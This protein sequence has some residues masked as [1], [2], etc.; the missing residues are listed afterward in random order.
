MVFRSRA[1]RD[2]CADSEAM[3]TAW[4][5]AGARVVRRTLQQLAATS[6]LGDLA[7]LPCANN[8]Q[9]D[10]RV[11]IKL[12]EGISMVVSG[13]KESVEIRE[14]IHDEMIVIEQIRAPRFK[15]R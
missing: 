9:S 4:G 5:F 15:Q 14:A 11:E 2:R 8:V 10:G 3:V 6:N 12:E 13:G 7:F 1:L